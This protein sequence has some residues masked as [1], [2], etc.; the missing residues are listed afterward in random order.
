MSALGHP[1]RRP[2]RRHPVTDTDTA[3]AAE[4]INATGARDWSQHQARQ[5]HTQALHELHTVNPNPPAAAHLTTLASLI[6]NRQH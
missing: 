3:R 1:H 5:L 4:L 2:R 6:I